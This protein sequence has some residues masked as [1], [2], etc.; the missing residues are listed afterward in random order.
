MT[1]D[2]RVM[3]NSVEAEQALLGCLMLAP[4]YLDECMETIRPENFYRGAHSC[5]YQ[6]MMEE[7]SR[8]RELD[9]ISLKDYLE[10]KG[11]LEKSGGAAYLVEISSTPSMASRWKRYAEIVRKKAISRRLVEVGTTVTAIGYDDNDDV[12][13]ALAV[14][15][16]IV[17][18]VVLANQHESLPVGTILTDL[19][20]SINEGG[21]QYVTPKGVPLARLRPGDLMVVGAG[22]SAGKTAITL[23]WCDDWSKETKV[24]YFEYEMTEADLMSRLIC[25]HAGVSMKQVQDCDFD[26]EELQRVQD[27]MKELRTRQLVVEEVWCDVQ[28]LMAKIRKAAMQGTEII[29]ID[30]LGL[31]PFKRN[32]QMAEAKAIGVQVTNPLKRLA[33]ELGIKI[34]L[35]V[36]MNREGQKSDNF[37][38]LYHLRDSG[39]IEQDA[40]VVLML[41]SDKSLRDDEGA[42]GRI[43]EQSGVLTQDE[44]FSDDFNLIRI[45][46]EKNR[47][48]A[49]GHAWARFVGENF[50]YTYY[51]A[52]GSTSEDKRLF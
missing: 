43:R 41:W 45:G 33:A 13:D 35:L 37:P 51:N 18:G 12:D 24:A 7:R 26:Q 29:V 38:K 31:V 40:S 14:T 2:T 3:P 39:E 17:M 23:D 5:I 15:Q 16:A 50:K 9:M 32:K 44:L 8:G 48:G 49:L 19:W 36:Q 4:K 22:T 27:A 6:A 10:S 30:H 28:I 1:T 34:V 21:H 20:K 47:N 11:D 42:R 52:D 46:V 25:H